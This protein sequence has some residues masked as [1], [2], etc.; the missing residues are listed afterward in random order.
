MTYSDEIKKLQQ[1]AFAEIYKITSGDETWYYTT[2]EKD[3]VFESNTYLSSPIKR[4]AFS[5][6]E[7]LKSQRIKITAPLT[8]PLKRYI[9]NSPIEPTKIII[10]RVFIDNPAFFKI[11]FIGEIIGVTMLKGIADVD[12]ESISLIFR[13]RLPL[14]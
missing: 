1:G 10:T 5:F 9:G 8:D 7:K 13:Q 14:W 12:C 3:V 4:S 6:D 2:Y 11:I